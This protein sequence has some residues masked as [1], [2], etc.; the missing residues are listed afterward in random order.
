MN[1]LLTWLEHGVDHD[2]EYENAINTLTPEDVKAAVQELLSQGNM[3]NIA[4]FP[5]E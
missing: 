4:S 3:I 2:V 1:C 5:A